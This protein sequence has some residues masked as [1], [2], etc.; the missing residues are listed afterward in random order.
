MALVPDAEFLD[1]V[2]ELARQRPRAGQA[3]RPAAPAQ[4][5]RQV[6]WAQRPRRGPPRVALP[7]PQGTVAPKQQSPRAWHG[8]FVVAARPARLGVAGVCP[9][10][11]LLYFFCESCPT[12]MRVTAKDCGPVWMMENWL[13]EV[14]V[15]V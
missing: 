14:P 7:G 9:G 6:A 10:R 8:G 3:A 1:F 2:A 4:A 12:V 13:Y 5:Q 11:Y 15:E